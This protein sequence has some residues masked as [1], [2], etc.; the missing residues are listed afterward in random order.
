MSFI[1]K[2]WI[3]CFCQ[4]IGIDQF[5]NSY[6]SSKNKNYLGRN[7]RFVV[8]NGNGETSKVPPMWHSWLHYISDDIPSNNAKTYD[9][10]QK[11]EPNLT[12]TK[13]AY[14]PAQ[15]KNIKL[16]TYSKW[17]PNEG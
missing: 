15:Y 14:N 12:G 16:K 17:N 6:F 11:Y 5:G 9:W 13:Y 7:K 1:D 3:K 2:L 8:Y 4:K 10:Q